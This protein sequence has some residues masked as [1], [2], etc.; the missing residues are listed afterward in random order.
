M[1]ATAQKVRHWRPHFHLFLWNYSNLLLGHASPSPLPSVYSLGMERPVC[2]TTL[3]T[4]PSIWQEIKSRGQFLGELRGPFFP[5]LHPVPQKSPWQDTHAPWE[6]SS[7]SGLISLTL[8]S[9][10]WGWVLKHH[11][12]MAICWT[13]WTRSLKAVQIKGDA[14]QVFSHL[15]LV[16]GSLFLVHTIKSAA[17]MKALT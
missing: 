11:G 14:G 9:V 12:P 13:Q 10:D 2:I 5:F 15:E 8:L 7:L 6:L 16:L 1:L 17:E 3:S 4:F